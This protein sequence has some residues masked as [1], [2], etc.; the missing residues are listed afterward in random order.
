MTR[1]G[2]R[3]AAALVLV[4]SFA[5]P[6]GAG[7]PLAGKVIVLD[8]GHA[9]INFQSSVINSGKSRVTV[10]EHRL[11]LSIATHLAKLL[12]A[13]GATVYLTRT[14][15]DYWRAS[16]SAI[17]DNKARA[18]FANEVGA[19]ALLAIHCDW[20]PSRKFYGVTTFYSK[21]GS[22]RLGEEIQRG[23]VKGLKTRNRGVI[24]TN[25]TVLDNAE[26]PAVLLEAGFMS[27]RAEGRKLVTTAYQKK[28]A[29]SLAAA[30]R[31]YFAG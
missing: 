7:L 11:T 12:E 29:A 9:A 31:R 22:R 13:D 17:E 24:R 8:P 19:D 21:A 27:N 30:L 4:L 16:Y 26:M 28:V 5:V 20:H 3:A 23:L 25:F 6:S 10:P 14:S 2:I 1:A 18:Y 15:G